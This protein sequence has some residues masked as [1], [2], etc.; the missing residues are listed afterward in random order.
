[1]STWA[2]SVQDH[3]TVERT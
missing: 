1:M 3:G 2:T